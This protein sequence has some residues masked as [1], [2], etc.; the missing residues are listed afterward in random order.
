MR[1]KLVFVLTP[2]DRARCAQESIGLCDAAKYFLPLTAQMSHTPVSRGVKYAKSDRFMTKFEVYRDWHL[3][4][5]E[6]YWVPLKPHFSSEAF[7]PPT[8]FQYRSD[9]P[10]HEFFGLPDTNH[11]Q[12]IQAAAVQ[13]TAQSKQEI[14]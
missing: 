5:N 9:V 1:V 4:F 10:R 13:V 12:K 3:A 6:R 2:E 14:H 11:V 7:R 8:E